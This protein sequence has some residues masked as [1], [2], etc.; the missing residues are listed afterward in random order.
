MSKIPSSPVDFSATL[1]GFAVVSSEDLTCVAKELVTLHVSEATNRQ[2]NT[3]NS[4]AEFVISDRFREF[5]D[6]P[7]R[8]FSEDLSKMF[9]KRLEDFGYL[10]RKFGDFVTDE[11]NLGFENIYW[12]IVR[13]NSPS[14][15]GP[16]HADKWFWDLGEAPFPPTHVRVKVW[17]P[18][19]QDD[20]NPSLL[21]L[22]G[23]QNNT[24][25]YESRKDNLGKRKPMF[26]ED[27][28]I[29]SMIPAP[30]KVGQAVIFNDNLLH[31]GRP[32]GSDR[33]SIEFTLG[34]R[35]R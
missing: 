18:L 17:L 22:P 1:E 28:V 26:N 20:E 13:K 10:D 5:K 23:S 4:A 30:A 9:A 8:T 16:V 12:R 2:F 21:V 32:S 29:Q 33:V 27:A 11:E 6:K 7:A 19:I 31:A 24:Y 3:L 14:D 35:R 25:L 34:I 15:V